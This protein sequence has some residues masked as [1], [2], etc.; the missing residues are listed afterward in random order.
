MEPKRNRNYPLC[1]EK[2]G[3]IPKV[4]KHTPY[5]KIDTACT[6]MVGIVNNARRWKSDYRGRILIM[7]HIGMICLLLSPI[8][9]SRQYDTEPASLMN[10]NVNFGVLCM[11][12]N[13]NVNWNIQPGGKIQIVK[14]IYRVNQNNNG[15]GGT[16][17]YHWQNMYS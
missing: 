17:Y 14:L 15:R 2:K 5:E 1:V 9:T 13:E 12:V 8:V 16:H 11:N 7:I 3:T 10:C 6:R 4:Y